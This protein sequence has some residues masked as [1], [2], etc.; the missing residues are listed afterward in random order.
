MSNLP[1]FGKVCE[2]LRE[3]VPGELDVGRGH[4]Q[5]LSPDVGEDVLEFVTVNDAH[6]DLLALQVDDGVLAAVFENVLE[7]WDVVVCHDLG[8]FISASRVEHIRE[9]LKETTEIK[10]ALMLMQYIT[11]QKVFGIIFFKI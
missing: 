11:R 3:D 9:E 4:G 6:V 5:V 10:S 2:Q 1:R 7:G 8:I